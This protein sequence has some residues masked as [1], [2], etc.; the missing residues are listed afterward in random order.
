[1]MCVILEIRTAQKASNSTRY[2]GPI[3]WNVI[4]ERLKNITSLKIFKKEIKR[5]K[6]KKC[7]CRI[8]KNYVHNLG[9]I[10]L[11]EKNL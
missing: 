7:P 9:F 3:I 8:C 10:K 11:F 6:P 2:F 1:M 4:P 5:W